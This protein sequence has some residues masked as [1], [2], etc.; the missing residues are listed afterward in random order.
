M[1]CFTDYITV[2]GSCSDNTSQSTYTL[3]D[4]GITLSEL[5]EI[6]TKDYKNGKTLGEEKISFAI[7]Q[8]ENNIHNHFASKFRSNSILDNQR[9]GFQQPNLQSVVP[10]AA[11]SKGIEIE[12]CSNDSFV[13]V[14]ISEI[15]LFT[16][17]T[18]NI[19]VKIYDIFQNK[20]LDTITVNCVAGEITTAFVNKTYSSD[21]KNLN[22]ALIY[23][24]TGVTSFKTQVKQGSCSTCTDG[25]PTWV[26]PYFKARGIKIDNTLD[27][28]KSSLKGI[29][30][31]GGLS[32]Q[33]NVNC[34]Y[35]A[36][37]CSIRNMLALPVLYKSGEQLME[38]ILHN[39][40]RLNSTTILDLEKV[41]AR[42]KMYAE[43][44][45]SSIDS[46]LKNIKLP[47][48]SKCFDCREKSKTVT[49]LP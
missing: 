9:I 7:K 39:S 23:D 29:A 45:Q 3:K 21:R 1:A 27:V 31:T 34:N 33:Y 2:D 5:N 48:D 36:W 26:S 41:E 22:I 38:F 25:A 47:S 28:I 19:D 37:I 8:V 18:G 44:Y 15:S 12:M 30:E 4:I 46:I 6:V 13:D 10:L 24:S 35:N 16:N 20:L 14:Y 32:L 11:Y 42:W 49:M 40:D 43:K 17:T